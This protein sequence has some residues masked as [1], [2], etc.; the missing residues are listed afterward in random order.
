MTTIQSALVALGFLILGGFVYRGLKN[1]GPHALGWMTKIMLV[2]TSIMLFVNINLLSSAR[3]QIR[4]QETIFKYTIPATL[5]LVGIAHNPAN[6]V[7]MED[8]RIF[9]N[10]GTE[11]ERVFVVIGYPIYGIMDQGKLVNLY[12]DLGGQ[13]KDPA[14]QDTKNPS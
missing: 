3:Q 7:E 13:E 6:K 4:D 9:I 10:K 14:E 2:L 5:E 11:Q 12:K 8:T 1:S